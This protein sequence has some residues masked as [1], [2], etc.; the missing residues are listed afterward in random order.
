MNQ[1]QRCLVFAPVDSLGEKKLPSA[2]AE[3]LLPERTAAQEGWPL[4]AAPSALALGSA[5]LSLGVGVA[6]SPL[7][8]PLWPTTAHKHAGF[9]HLL[10]SN[11]SS[12]SVT[13]LPPLLNPPFSFPL[14][15]NFLEVW[16]ELPSL[17]SLAFSHPM[18]WHLLWLL[19]RDTCAL[20]KVS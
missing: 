6:G 18:Q 12:S 11:C 14:T 4:P 2:S 10:E 16:S 5:A 9:F 15:Q 3:V 8:Q 20:I 17:L 19:P 7:L 13:S 1:S